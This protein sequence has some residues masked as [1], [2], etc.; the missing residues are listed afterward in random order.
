MKSVLV[1]AGL[2]VLGMVVTLSWWTITGTGSNDETVHGIPSKVW[3]G[4]AAKLEVEVETTSAAR[5]NIG[6]DERDGDGKSMEAWTQISP[7]THRWTVDVPSSVG[8]YI[9]LTA[10]NPKSGDKL[11]WKILVDGT[12]VDEQSETLE[13][14]L[15]PGW[16]FGL[17]TFM[18]DYSKGE[19]SDDEE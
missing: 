13:E 18:E 14:A 3:E 9:D 5:I 8:G 16:A 11:T 12:T 7:G 6:F 2:A 10:E 19:P 15:K 17:Q 4:G 1:R